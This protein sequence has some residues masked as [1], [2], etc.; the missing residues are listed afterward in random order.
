MD[1]GVSQ[2]FS[3]TLR[4]SS[5]GLSAN[6]RRLA[7]SSTTNDVALVGDRRLDNPQENKRLRTTPDSVYSSPKTPQA[8]CPVLEK[9][10]LLVEENNPLQGDVGG[11]GLDDSRVIELNSSFCVQSNPADEGL[12]LDKTQEIDAGLLLPTSC[13]VPE[14]GRKIK[15]KG[16]IQFVICSRIRGSNDEWGLFDKKTLEQMINFIE[17]SNANSA[18]GLSAAYKYANMWGKVPIIG[19]FS[20]DVEAM[21]GYRF[22]IEL[23]KKGNLEFQTFPRQTL[24]RRLALT[25]MMWPNLEGI[26][27][28]SFSP[29]LLDRNRGLRGG[30]K[31]LKYKLFRSDDLDTKGQSML[32]ARLLQLDADETFLKSLA[33]YPRS[34]RF[35]LGVASVI[36]RG[37]E[38]AEEPT[39][40]TWG[41]RRPAAKSGS[42]RDAL[43]LGSL[44]R[45]S[46][47]LNTSS[48]LMKSY[49][50]QCG[51]GTLEDAEKTIRGK[52]NGT[53]KAN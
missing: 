10:A 3:G 40:S 41:S 15:S 39:G 9:I 12:E 25:V 16:V 46:D 21:N 30:V 52:R 50:D 28:Q 20:R 7:S 13:R 23:Y 48:E 37:G 53:R 11:I 33:K 32:G 35:G 4:R 5:S 1:Q 42:F 31:V 19:L 22:K 27:T 17:N 26:E 44:T 34:H 36:I 43:V 47:D 6:E 51:D 38:R 14:R 45:K 24:N 2:R 29:N 8:P 49:A 18:N